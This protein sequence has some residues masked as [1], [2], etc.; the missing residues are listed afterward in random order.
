MTINANLLTPVNCLIKFDIRSHYAG[1][2]CV[3]SVKYTQLR[4][5][6]LHK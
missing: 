3:A 6:Q 2:E 4:I 1:G 5:K